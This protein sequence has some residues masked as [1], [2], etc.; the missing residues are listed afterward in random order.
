MTPTQGVGTGYLQGSSVGQTLQQS[1]PLPSHTGTGPV[2]VGTTGTTGMT[3]GVTGHHHSKNAT[4]SNAGQSGSNVGQ[5]GTNVGQAG[6]NVGQVGNNVG[7]IIFRPLEGRFNKDKD[8]IG[9]M[10][11]YCKFKIGWRRGKSSVAKG[12]GTNPTWVGDAITIKVKNQEFAKLKVK[13]KDRL[14]LDD[15]LGTAKIPL[16]QVFQQGKVTEWIP[17]TKKDVVTGEI[18]LEMEFLPSTST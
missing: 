13:D 5:T 8:L 9:K 3:R 4:G 14:R 6:T 11:P 10:D 18:Q 2:L 7:Q 1:T 17:I 12:Q 16:A 15:R